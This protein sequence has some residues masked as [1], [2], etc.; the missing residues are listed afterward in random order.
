MISKIP[1]N[2]RSCDGILLNVWPYNIKACL[3]HIAHVTTRLNCRFL[4]V[5]LQHGLRNDFFSFFQVTSTF[6]I[7]YFPF[8]FGLLL[9]F[10]IWTFI[11][12]FYL[13]FY[14]SFLFELLFP[15]SLVQFF[16]NSIVVNHLGFF[17]VFFLTKGFLTAY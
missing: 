17:Q 9:P 4:T 5:I 11:S 10:S 15:F 8:L 14:F 7:F 16:F 1:S 13:E 6:S 2:G 3:F 12:L